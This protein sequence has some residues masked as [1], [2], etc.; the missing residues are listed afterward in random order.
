L[1]VIGIVTDADLVVAVII[2]PFDVTQMLDL[3]WAALAA[4]MT[5]G[6]LQA[7]IPWLKVWPVLVVCPCG[8][9]KENDGEKS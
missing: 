6:G 3:A 2:A 9:A 7:L 4:W 1:R 5:S 8:N